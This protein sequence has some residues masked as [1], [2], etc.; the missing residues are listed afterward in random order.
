M[1]VNL[2]NISQLKW[3]YLFSNFSELKASHTWAR[4]VGKCSSPR[5][6]KSSYPKPGSSIYRET[7]D[8]IIMSSSKS[9]DNN[10]QF[11]IKET[12]QS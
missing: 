10:E 3:Q 4:N 9:K 6:A 5:L 12:V 2:F 1:G 7:S 8:V 11:G